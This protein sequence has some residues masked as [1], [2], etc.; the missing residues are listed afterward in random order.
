MLVLEPSTFSFTHRHTNTN[1]HYY[2]AHVYKTHIDHM[3]T[4]LKLPTSNFL[5]TV[6]LQSPINMTV[7]IFVYIVHHDL[8]LILFQINKTTTDKFNSFFYYIPIGVLKCMYLEIFHGDGKMLKVK[9]SMWKL[10]EINI[11]DGTMG[12]RCFNLGTK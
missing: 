12:R 8:T 11:F 3:H 5:K 4:I 7:K 6:N 9:I 10:M 1:D 2:D